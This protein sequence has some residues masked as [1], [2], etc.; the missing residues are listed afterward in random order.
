MKK[1]FYSTLA[2]LT[3]SVSGMAN[4]VEIESD[5]F[6]FEDTKSN[7]PCADSAKIVRDRALNDGISTEGANTIFW[8]YYNACMS[9]RH[10]DWEPITFD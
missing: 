3:F 6:I 2:V 1:L 5:Q 10:I 4:T 9:A 7:T 8:T